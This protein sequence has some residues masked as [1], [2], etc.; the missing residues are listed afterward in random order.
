MV[1]VPQ[2]TNYWG[3]LSNEKRKKPQNIK[4]WK[5]ND[6]KEKKEGGLVERPVT[7]GKGTGT[8]RKQSTR[9]GGVRGGAQG[10]GSPRPLVQAHPLSVMCIPPILKSPL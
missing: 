1:A 3:I 5:K 6:K 9:C 10:N 4:K 8:P 2:N 7:H